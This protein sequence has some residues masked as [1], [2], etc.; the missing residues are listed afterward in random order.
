MEEGGLFWLLALPHVWV[1]DPHL[2]DPQQ[3]EGPQLPS[4]WCRL[5]LGADLYPL[6]P[7]PAGPL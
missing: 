7:L 2:P 4:P 5:P 6:S 1:S 3:A